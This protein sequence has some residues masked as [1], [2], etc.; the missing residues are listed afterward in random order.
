MNKE[1]GISDTSGTPPW[2][3]ESTSRLRQIV[4]AP[5]AEV[6]E[7]KIQGRKARKMVDS[8]VLVPLYS[9][10]RINGSKA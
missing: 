5:P 6:K 2:I 1:Q 7:E 4:Y 9:L 8:S 3:E 10:W